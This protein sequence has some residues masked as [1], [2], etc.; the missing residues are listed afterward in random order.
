M[1]HNDN[2]SI[3]T[4]DISPFLLG[5]YCAK[6]EVA[7]AVDLAFQNTGFL[8]ITGHGVKQN[9][10]HN[11]FSELNNFFSLPLNKKEQSRS[12][13][14]DNM[15]GYVGLE[16]NTL[17][18]SM[19]DYSPPDLFER[20][21]CGIPDIPNDDFHNAR[22]DSIFQTNIWPKDPPEMGASVSDYFRAMEKLTANLLRIC[23]SALKVD[24]NF[25]TDKIDHHSPLLSANLYPNQ[26][27]TPEAGQLRAGAHTDY[28]S[29]T[30]L[31]AEDKPGGLQV[32]DKK[33]KW[34]D[35]HPVKDSFII[36][37]GDLMAYWTNDRW[38]STLH[39]V[40]NPPLSEAEH[41][42]R[43]SV[44]FFHHPN[45]DT[46]IECIST[47]KGKHNHPKYPPITAGE[48][49]MKKFLKQRS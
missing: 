44:V 23:A 33:G 47:C 8:I 41:S 4:I 37:L 19:S 43:L 17:S 25:F 32:K 21:T 35:V 11:A 18:Y 38:L 24:E 28:G 9:I 48:Y 49:I 27:K 3:E 46:I 16:E 30:I 34:L 12:K 14:N 10:I 26:I 31:A 42:R 7:H 29:I 1:K 22:R 20:Y 40:K 39:R 36:N 45:Q 6:L 5:D 2:N 13:R 15:R